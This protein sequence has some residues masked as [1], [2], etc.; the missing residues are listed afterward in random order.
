MAA[1][2]VPREKVMAAAVSYPLEMLI[3]CV[4]S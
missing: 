2:T 1:D 4:A 3:G